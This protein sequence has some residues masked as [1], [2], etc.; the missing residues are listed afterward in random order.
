MDDLFNVSL[1]DSSDASKY[2]KQSFVPSCSYLLRKSSIGKNADVIVPKNGD[3]KFEEKKRIRLYAITF[4]DN[5]GNVKKRLIGLYCSEIVDIDERA[6]I[7]WYAVFVS[8]YKNEKGEYTWGTKTDK[9]YGKTIIK[10]SHVSDTSAEEESKYA[11]QLLLL[12]L[13]LRYDINELKQ[14][15]GKTQYSFF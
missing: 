14:T 10:V 8:G 4:K 6:P 2:M 5:E 9:K 15:K 1:K 13:G 12:H 11:I 7:Y 3:P